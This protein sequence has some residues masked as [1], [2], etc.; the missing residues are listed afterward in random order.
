MDVKNFVLTYYKDATDGFH[1]HRIEKPTEAKKLHSHEFFQI[2]YV[3]KGSITHYLEN[4]TSRLTAGD[5]FI[6]PP[7][8]KHRI[9]EDK[10]TAFY[11]FSFLESAISG[12]G[13]YMDFLKSFS[14][15]KEIKPKISV[16]VDKV[17]QVENIMHE[18]YK[19]F[20]DKKIA[21]GDIIKSYAVVLIS[22]FSREYYKTHDNIALSQVGDVKKF[23]LYCTDYMKENFEKNINLESMVKLSAMSKSSFCNAFL[24]TVGMTFNKYLN[25]LRINKA[26]EYIEK[27]YKITAI[28]GLCGYN[29]FTTFYRNFKNIMGVSPKQYKN[30]HM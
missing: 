21:S 2:Y 29:D 4:H 7:G 6:I 18:I 5:M 11:S 16:P 17:M 28:Y 25:T 27:G 30:N 15:D 13:F 22:L 23:I 3:E 26:T 12:N 20:N 8:I 9:E 1:I 19:E 24:N 10:D 14:I